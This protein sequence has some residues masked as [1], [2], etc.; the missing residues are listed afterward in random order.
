MY[1]RGRVREGVGIFLKLFMKLNNPIKQI[2]KK[3]R[4]KATPQEILLWSRLKRNQ[5]GFKFRRQHSFGN[6]IVDFY[7]KEKKLVIELDGWQHK[8]EFSGKTE[9]IRTEF[10]ERKNLKI[11]RFWNNE[12][13]NNLDGVMLKI[14]EY[15]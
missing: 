7:C 3:L 14:K 10:L 6:Y 11:L 8:D 13:N 1:S 5:I 4:N 15:L 12:I 9:R 2:R